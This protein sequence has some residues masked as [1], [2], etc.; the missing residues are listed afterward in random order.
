MFG[1]SKV[2]KN[3]RIDE[4]LI[5]RLK[6][7]VNEINKVAQYDY[8]TETE[9]IERLISRY[10]PHLVETEIESYNTQEVKKLFKD[11]SPHDNP[12]NARKDKE[13]SKIYQ[14]AFNNRFG[15][16]FDK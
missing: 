12:D 15:K 10:L 11:S 4:N 9:I 2:S 6:F 1:M 5:S 3:F 7:A 13:I 16:D 8:I 14:Y